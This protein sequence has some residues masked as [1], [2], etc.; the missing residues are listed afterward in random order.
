MVAAIIT[1]S[2]EVLYS[3]LNHVAEQE[4]VDVEPIG[5]ALGSDYAPTEAE[6]TPTLGVPVVGAS[7]DHRAFIERLGDSYLGFTDPFDHVSAIDPDAV[8]VA[9][10][11]NNAHI[12]RFEFPWQDLGSPK[13]IKNF[14]E[15]QLT[16][17]RDSRAYLGIYCETDANTLTPNARRSYYWKGLVHA[18]DTIKVP[19]NRSG[20]KIRIR[21][22]AIVFNS[23]RFM[24]RDA[25]IGFAVGGAD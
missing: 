13:I 17:E 11:F 7:A 15:V 6:P 9:E 5:T 12:A 25:T 3:A 19:V 4:A 8:E 22:V 21:V 18:R 1:R 16:L 2:G 23:A 10:W 14:L 24:V 20:R